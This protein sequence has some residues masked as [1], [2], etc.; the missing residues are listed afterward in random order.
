M[1][2]TKNTLP[3]ILL[4]SMIGVEGII[5]KVIKSKERMNR[6]ILSGRSIG[7]MLETAPKN[8]INETI[9]RLVKNISNPTRDKPI[10]AKKFLR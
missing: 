2:M 1:I 8:N 10:N 3:T 4:I 5:G 9:L 6:I 7:R